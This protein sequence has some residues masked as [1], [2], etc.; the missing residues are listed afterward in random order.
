MGFDDRSANRQS[1]PHAVRL[2]REEC[3]KDAAHVVRFN[4]SAR[5]ST[6]IST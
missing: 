2:C 1:H 6:T 3:F 5:V 4:A